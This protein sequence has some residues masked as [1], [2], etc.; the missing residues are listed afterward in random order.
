MRDL[1]HYF[2]VGGASSAVAAGTVGAV[3]WGGA[4]L[5][6]LAAIGV[7]ALVAIAALET[8][9]GWKQATDA[10]AKVEAHEERLAKVEKEAEEAR[11]RAVSAQVAANARG[12]VQRQDF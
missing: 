3:L 2:A 11:K 5:V 1:T 8:R 4:A 12:A 6:A 10:L 7:V 9:D